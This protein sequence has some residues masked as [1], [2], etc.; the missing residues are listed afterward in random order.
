MAGILMNSL[1]LRLIL[2]AVSCGFSLIELI[3]PPLYAM[4]MVLDGIVALVVVF[5]NLTTLILAL[6][7]LFK[8]HEDLKQFYP[9]YPI[10]PGG[11]LARFMI[12]FYNIWGIWNTL[13]TLAGRFKGENDPKIKESGSS[14][15]S[16]VPILYVIGAISSVLGRILFRQVLENPETI[17][18]VLLL[19]TTAVDVGLAYVLLELGRTMIAGINVK[20][21]QPVSIEPTDT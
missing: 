18:P 11:A 20:A 21:A 1:W 12:P 9:D 2:A 3:L 19:A 8:L 7:W 17:S 4:L 16:W 6:I 14:I 15:Q 10:G 13:T 5:V